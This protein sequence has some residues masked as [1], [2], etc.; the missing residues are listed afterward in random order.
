M[1]TWNDF[2]ENVTRKKIAYIFRGLPGAGKSTAV[3]KLLV[4]HGVSHEGHV[5]STDNHWIPDT[6]AKRKAGAYVGHQEEKDEYARNY[7]PN[8]TQA[9]HAGNLSAFKKAVDNGVSPVILDNTNFLMSYMRPYVEYA[10]KAEYEVIIKYPESDLW[11]Q[12]YPY[13]S[14]KK[15]NAK[16]L[17]EFAQQ[18]AARNQHGA[19]LAVIKDMINRWHHAP[20]MEDILKS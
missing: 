1:L 16:E 10:Q 6:R 15:K 20:K 7:D 4:Q 5:F 18:L 11:K 2:L 12:Y 3:N 17:E 14:D 19:S 9:A 8:K 13:L